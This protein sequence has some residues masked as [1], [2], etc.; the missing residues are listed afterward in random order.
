MYK[1]V[2]FN[3]KETG[4]MLYVKCALQKLLRSQFSII[5]MI[6]V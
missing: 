2:R 4:V 3:A 5:L 6:I 1:W